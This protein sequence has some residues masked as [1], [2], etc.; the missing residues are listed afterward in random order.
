M[1]ALDNQKLYPSVP[2]VFSLP[3]CVFSTI[4]NLLDLP[5]VAKQLQGD[6]ACL[7]VSILEAGLATCDH[8]ELV[9]RQLQSFM[10]PDSYS[11]TS[12]FRFLQQRFLQP[13]SQVENYQVFLGISFCCQFFK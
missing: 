7:I 3:K 11:N 8:V 4:D 2:I 13:N 1:C 12:L 6:Q 10:D 5:P 9:I